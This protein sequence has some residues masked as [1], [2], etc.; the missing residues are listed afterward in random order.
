MDDAPDNSEQQPQEPH[1]H[2]MSMSEFRALSDA[3]AAHARGMQLAALERTQPVVAELIGENEVMKTRV[4]ELEAKIAELE[5][6]K[7]K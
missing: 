7:R 2:G 4:A 3:Q 5:S 6:K 1:V